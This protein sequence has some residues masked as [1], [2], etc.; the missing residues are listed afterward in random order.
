MFKFVQGCVDD[1]RKW[2]EHV[3]AVIFKELGLLPNCVSPAVYSGIFNGHLL[4][5]VR[6]TDNFF[7]ACEH[8]S[9]YKD[10]IAVFKIHWTVHIFCIVNTFFGL[11]FVSSHD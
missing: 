10:I 6:A 9:A 3:V 4:I 11:H 5:L 1:S 8:E 2:G 7:C